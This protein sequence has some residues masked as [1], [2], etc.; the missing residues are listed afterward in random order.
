MLP[1]GS[2]PVVCSPIGRQS[3]TACGEEGGGGCGGWLGG[4]AGPGQGSFAYRTGK[5][6]TGKGGWRGNRLGFRD[7]VALS[8][9]HYSYILDG[10]PRSKLCRLNHER[11]PAEV[12]E[13]FP[14]ALLLVT[15]HPALKSG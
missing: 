4:C 3:Q 7:V 1:P 6:P 11:G 13:Y 10:S 5:G 15:R 8:M 2:G 12:A 9:S 14:V